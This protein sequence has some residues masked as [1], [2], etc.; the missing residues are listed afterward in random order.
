MAYP[1]GPP[2]AYASF[3]KRLIDDYG[4]EIRTT[5]AQYRDTADGKVETF[6]YLFRRVNGVARVAWLPDAEPTKEM[7]RTVVRSICTRLH[8]DNV[9]FGVLSEDDG[10]DD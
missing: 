6:R 3:L 2:I 4:C 10:L 1:F 9:E 5:K 8:L 7:M